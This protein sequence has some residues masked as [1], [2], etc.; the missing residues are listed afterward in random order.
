M[1]V[2]SKNS[3]LL[4]L[5][6]DTFTD[7]FFEIYAI[8]EEQNALL[9]ELVLHLYTTNKQAQQE[10]V[11]K[12]LLVRPTAQGYSLFFK[13]GDSIKLEL[14]GL[15]C[16]LENISSKVM[17]RVEAKNYSAIFALKKL[18]IETQNVTEE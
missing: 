16:V 2:V 15:V 14:E 12:T 9:H 1:N 17:L 11:Q 6:L 4:G 10:R 8:A 5:C 18:Y 13:D 3:Y 7:V